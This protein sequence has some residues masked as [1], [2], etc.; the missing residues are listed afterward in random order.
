MEKYNVLRFATWIEEGERAYALI[1]GEN[2][3]DEAINC[4]RDGDMGEKDE[5]GIYS[6]TW[7]GDYADNADTFESTVR[8]MTKEEV[9]MYLE[10]V[11]KDV[12]LDSDVM[13]DKLDNGYICVLRKD[14]KVYNSDIF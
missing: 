8:P 12:L 10:Y 9:D 14:K 4:C 6:R 3:F 1:D 13:A 5:R 7:V 11:G 2:W